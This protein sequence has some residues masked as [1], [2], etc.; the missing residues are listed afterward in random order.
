[1]NS[2]FKGITVKQL[3]EFLS[4]YDD[5]SEIIVYVFNEDSVARSIKEFT[6]H[7]YNDDEEI[8]GII[9]N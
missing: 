8:Q 6:Y 9:I 1:M 7:Y 5:D 3:K 2:S 4:K